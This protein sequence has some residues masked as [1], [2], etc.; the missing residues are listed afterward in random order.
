MWI[1]FI[2]LVYL[3]NGKIKLVSNMVNFWIHSNAKQALHRMGNAL[4]ACIHSKSTYTVRI[5]T[6]F[7]NSSHLKQSYYSRWGHCMQSYNKKKSISILTGINP[8]V[9]N[10]N[11]LWQKVYSC[12]VILKTDSTSYFGCVAS[13][14]PVMER[15]FLYFT[16]ASPNHT[17]T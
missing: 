13:F 7:H 14:I 4:N 2:L 16:Y 17:V 10:I 5:C 9:I 1:I 12:L 15:A 6:D 8:I 3:Y 11:W